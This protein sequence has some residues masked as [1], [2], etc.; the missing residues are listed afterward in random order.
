MIIQ[1]NEAALRVKCTDATL[2]EA[3]DIIATL[4]RELEYSARL[5]NPGIGLAATQCNIQKNVAIVRL[6]NNH[7]VNLVNCKIQNAYDEQMFRNE[8]CLSFPARIENTMRH[9]ELHIVNNLVYPHS[10]IVSGLMAVVCE[11]ELEHMSG[12]L[13]FDH[14]IKKIENK[15]KPRPN[16]PCVCGKPIKFKRCCGR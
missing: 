10:F 3:K 12:V 16:D 14:A 1:N 5:G 2:D 8:G 13:F 11:H 6:N 4:E 9:Q 15:S 7:Q